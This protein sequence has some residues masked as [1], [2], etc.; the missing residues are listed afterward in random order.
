LFSTNHGRQTEEI[1]TRSVPFKAHKAG[2]DRER[3]FPFQSG[4]VKATGALNASRIARSS[5]DMARRTSNG[6]PF[7]CYTSKRLRADKKSEQ[8]QLKYTT[9]KGE[10]SNSPYTDLR[11]KFISISL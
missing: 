11:N 2:E 1:K 7:I 4:I 5:A 3:S 9:K 10:I 8:Y 6:C